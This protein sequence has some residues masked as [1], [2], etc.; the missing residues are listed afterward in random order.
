MN[1]ITEQQIAQIVPAPQDHVVVWAGGA[2]EE[3]R[4]CSAPVV[5]LALVETRTFRPRIGEKFDTLPL[6]EKRARCRSIRTSVEP[7]IRW[8]N[9]EAG[10]NGVEQEELVIA[11][12]DLFPP[13]MAQEYLGMR[14][15]AE[16]EQKKK[17]CAR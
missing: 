4:F 12:A 5:A 10:C 17:S 7:I 1:E 9:F 14:T 8:T 13:Y 16:L 2:D 3:P 11:S 6:S 15:S